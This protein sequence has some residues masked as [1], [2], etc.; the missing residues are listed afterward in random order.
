MSITQITRKGK[1]VKDPELEF[2]REARERS[3]KMKMAG[4]STRQSMRSSQRFRSQHEEHFRRPAVKKMVKNSRSNQIE[5]GDMICM[6]EEGRQVYA[7]SIDPIEGHA[8]TKRED[9][10]ISTSGIITAEPGWE[11]AR[12]YRKGHNLSVKIANKLLE[13]YMMEDMSVAYEEGKDDSFSFC[14]YCLYEY[15]TPIKKLTKN[16]FRLELENGDELVKQLKDGVTVHAIL[17]HGSLIGYVPEE[18]GS[19]QVVLKSMSRNDPRWEG[20]VIGR[21]GYIEFSQLALD[22]YID[23][24]IC[25]SRSM[26]LNKETNPSKDFVD[27]ILEHDPRSKS[28]ISIC[29]HD[30]STDASP[31]NS[32]VQDETNSYKSE[33]E[34]ILLVRNVDKKIELG[35]IVSR[36]EVDGSE[37]Y[38]VCVDFPAEETIEVVI[39]RVKPEDT[40]SSTL[41]S[42]IWK[43]RSCKVYRKGNRTAGHVATQ[44]MRHHTDYMMS[45]DIIK[46]D[47]LEFA[48]NCQFEKMTGYKDVV[49]NSGKIEEIGDEIVCGENY[50]SVYGIYGKDY[51]ISKQ[52]E[53]GKEAI[54]IHDIKHSKWEGFKVSRKGY[55]EAAGYAYQLLME[56]DIRS[57]G[58]LECVWEA[59]HNPN[60]EFTTQVLSK[61]DSIIDPSIPVHQVRKAHRIA[62]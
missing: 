61:F 10:L 51:V 27:L 26:Q 52:E 13:C 16:L 36:T 24:L 21:K 6:A 33:R 58:S 55:K 57:G 23:D 25:G 19:N 42:D 1:I 41:I 17:N 44:V 22:L 43:I 54:I 48:I 29:Y 62:S 2:Q 4:G 32:H 35:D 31:D 8:I 47:N 49:R 39:K 40:H 15:R 50:E 14:E 18:E 37:L 59:K 45:A 60:K 11:G 34:D 53:D 38:G 5:T 9:H 28:S 56:E 12:L 46:G 20:A 3:A 30:Q 7:I